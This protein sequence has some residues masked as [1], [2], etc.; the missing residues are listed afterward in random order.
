MRFPITR[1]LATAALLLTAGTALSQSLTRQSGSSQIGISG[2]T[3]VDD[4]DAQT[5]GRVSVAAVTGTPPGRQARTAAR[6]GANEMA[7]NALIR[8][9][10]FSHTD[11]FTLSEAN[12]DIEVAPSPIAYRAQLDFFLPPSYVEVKSNGEEFFN[13]IRTSMFA[14]LRAFQGP[15]SSSGDSKFFFQSALEASWADYE[16]SVSAMGDPQLDVTPLDSPIITDTGTSSFIRT[17]LVE[18]PSFVGHLDLGIVPAGVSYTVEYVMQARAEGI[19]SQCSG[20]AAINDPF[21]LD[22]D[23]VQ[24]APTVVLTMI[25][26]PEPAA[27][28]LFVSALSFLAFGRRFRPIR[29]RR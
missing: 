3:V 19:V 22:T 15:S 27:A 21:T 23:P 5:D 26:V 16:L 6:S 10:F 20:I 2:T 28:P 25:P 9:D 14:D 8:D 12:Y 24:M 29:I 7:V 11:F 1:S 17:T 4:H 18:F 13:L